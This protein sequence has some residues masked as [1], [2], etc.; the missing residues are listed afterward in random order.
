MDRSSPADG[1]LMKL[2]MALGKELMVSFGAMLAVVLLLA[3]S[4]MFGVKDLQRVFDEEIAQYTART[5]GPA[6]GAVHMERGSEADASRKVHARVSRTL[7]GAAG[8]GA[9]AAVVCAWAFRTVRRSTRSLR[10]TTGILHE[11]SS[12]AAAGARLVDQARGALEQGAAEQSRSVTAVRTTAERL[13]ATTQRN[14][15]HTSQSAA[16][17]GRVDQGVRTANTTLLSLQTSMEEIAASGNRTSGIIKVIDGIAFQTN[18][19]ALNAAVEAAR[20]GQ[21]GEGF[22]V[23][24]GEVR[25]LAQRCAEAARNT[26]SL[27]EE[28]SLKS[29]EGR[30]RLEEVIGAIQGITAASAEVRAL[31]EGVSAASQEQAGG[32]A[33][34]AGAVQQ[35]ERH[36]Q[37][38]ARSVESLA[39]AGVQIS[40]QTT[41]VESGVARLRQLVDGIQ[42]GPQ[43]P[44]A[45]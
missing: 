27:V 20:A 24:A 37:Q 11:G 39:S 3:A 22:A 1:L 17:M 33:E 25:N 7:Q 15:E 44:R 31:V 28:S 2:R 45:G 18:I 9:L 23:V 6:A 14:A 32:I 43:P 42:A 8:L 4:T 12:R 35:M 30:A 36:F 41:N 10:K 26:S 16:L 5:A 21:S 13:A 40:A 38:V 29:R 34:I 19:L